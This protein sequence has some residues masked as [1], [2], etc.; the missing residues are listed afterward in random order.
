MSK[1]EKMEEEIIEILEKHKS[2]IRGCIAFDER[3]TLKLTFEKIAKEI[4]NSDRVVVIPEIAKSWYEITGKNDNIS[5]GDCK[6]FATKELAEKYL[7]RD[8]YLMPQLFKVI[9]VREYSI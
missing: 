7:S 2:K 3:D 5:L 9:K 4:S 6:R 1:K 8:N